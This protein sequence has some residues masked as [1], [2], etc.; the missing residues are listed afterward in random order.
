MRTRVTS[1]TTACLALGALSI[2]VGAA[3]ATSNSGD[4]STEP[5]LPHSGA[6]PSGHPPVGDRL[7]EAAAINGWTRASCAACW[8]TDPTAWVTARPRLL[9]GPGRARRKG[10]A[11]GEA[12]TRRRR[13]PADTFLLHSKPGS[14]RCSTSTST[15]DTGQGRGAGRHSN[16]GSAWPPD[17]RRLRVHRRRE[18]DVQNVWQRVTED[19]APFDVDVTTRTPAPAAIDRTNAADQNFGTRA[20]ITRATR[21]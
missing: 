6:W 14:N 9:Q 8:L 2:G 20:L 10:C 21:R 5:S 17:D 1:L 16:G 3:S 18:G 4:R 13:T 15:A 11:D 19:Y 12:P 7:D